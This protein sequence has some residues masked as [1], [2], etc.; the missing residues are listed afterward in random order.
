LAEDE[1]TL[2]GQY[3]K[4]NIFF[5]VLDI[6]PILQDHRWLS[7]CIF[8]VKNTTVGF[9]LVRLSGRLLELVS[10]FIEPAKTKCV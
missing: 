7:G 5:S 3:H 9:L 10:Y 1:K 6:H 8:R 2:K 4:E